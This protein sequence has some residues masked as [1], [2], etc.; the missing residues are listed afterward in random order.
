[1][2]KIIKL[3][4]VGKNYIW[5]GERLKNEFGKQLDIS[6]LAECWECSTHPDGVSNAILMDGTVVPLIDLL[7]ENP[8]YLGK[9]ASAFGELPIIIKYIDANENLSIQVHPNDE[10]A[11]KYE[12]QHG[13]NEFWYI[14]DAT[15]GAEFIYGLE[16]PVSSQQLK[17]SIKEGDIEKHLHKVH[18]K[19]GDSFFVSAGTVHAIGQGNLIVEVQ[20]TSNVT[21]R[22]YDYNRKNSNGEKRELQIEK[23]LAVLNYD[24]QTDRLKKPKYVIY[25]NGFSEEEL[26]DCS[27]FKIRKIV[28]SDVFRFPVKRDSFTVFVCTSGMVNIADEDGITIMTISKGESVFVPAEETGALSFRGQAELLEVFI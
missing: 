27:F 24:V 10:Y 11:M 1:M 20:Q 8:H 25:H 17:A 21:Y 3:F 14:V 12:E 19:N 7:K 5:G 6:P 23:A 13:K 2:R 28:V 18:P 22:L 4:P 16:H 9:H 26:C 15:E